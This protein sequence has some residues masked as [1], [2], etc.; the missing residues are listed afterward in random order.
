VTILSNTTT[1]DWAK[2]V[3]LAAGSPLAVYPTAAEIQAELAASQPGSASVPVNVTRS[4]ASAS[5]EVL[6][7]LL[8]VDS[9]AV[10][11][12]A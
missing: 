8:P 12:T 7:P 2:P 9:Y 1:T 4:P 11:M 10:I 5:V 6:L 3:W